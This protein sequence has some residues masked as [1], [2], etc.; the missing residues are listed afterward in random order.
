MATY[1]TI[2]IEGLTSG[3]LPRRC[4][5]REEADLPEAVT[6]RGAI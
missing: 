4:N 3:E 2:T 1:E 5:L 6:G